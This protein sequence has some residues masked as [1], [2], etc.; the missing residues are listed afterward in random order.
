MNGAKLF[1]VAVAVALSVSCSAQQV[2]DDA[3][4]EATDRIGQEI[5]DRVASAYLD[6]LGPRLIREY[7]VGLMQVMFYQAGYYGEELE[8]EPGEYTIWS[9]DNSP[10]GET[11]E[12]AFLRRRDDGWEWWRLEVFGEQPESEEDM[13]LIM[14]ALFEPREDRR[15]IRRMLVQYPGDEEPTLMEIE[16]DEAERWAVRAER[17]SEEDLQKARVD[18]VEI[19]VPAGRFTTDHYQSDA[20]IDHEGQEF[21][22]EWWQTDGEV[23]GSVVQVRQIDLDDREELQTLRLKSYGDGAE[24]SVLGAF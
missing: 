4:G 1:A 2:F 10:Y 16:D 7:T 18:T 8:Y 20:V 6:D 14:E 19:E 22:T 17:W 15:Y 23:P 11:M 5:V 21:R 24:D 13:H 12:R 9:S 3:M